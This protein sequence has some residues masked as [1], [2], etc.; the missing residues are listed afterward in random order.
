MTQAVQHA[1]M[2]WTTLPWCAIWNVA[3][4]F[5]FLVQT[6]YPGKRLHAR[7]GGDPRAEMAHLEGQ[8]A[9]KQVK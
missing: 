5:V 3:I 1:S 6:F 8:L 7:L 9:E 2:P 4:L